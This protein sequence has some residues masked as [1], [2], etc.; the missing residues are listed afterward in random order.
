MQVSAEVRWFWR[1]QPSELE[2]WFADPEAHTGLRAGGGSLRLD[3]YLCD[4][5]GSELGIKLR[6]GKKG[7]EVKGLVAD[8]A[9]QL[10][11]EP[12]QGPVQIWCKWISE[13]LSLG[14]SQLVTT[15][16]RRWLRKFDTG[17]GRCREIG[18]DHDE[19]PI[20]GQP[21]PERGC[22]VEFTRVGA[23]GTEWWSFSFEAFG[24][25]S[26]VV[27]SLQSTCELLATRGP[28][29]IAKAQCISYPHWLA[30]RIAERDPG[31]A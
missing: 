23:F 8:G 1:R 2:K 24:K 21:L 17:N 30:E 14:A 25:L 4:P 31:V 13:A 28:P 16:K 20:E 26:N 3:E 19:K 7:L 9:S 15:E 29:T 27:E 6:A 22:N 12:F 5:Y 11:A 10:E 18:L